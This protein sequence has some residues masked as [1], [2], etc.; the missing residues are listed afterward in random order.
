MLQLE[1][2]ILELVLRAALL[3]ALFMVLLRIVPRRSVGELA[4][5]DLVFLL[6]ITNAASNSLGEFSS[7]TD[8][9]VQI[10]TFFGLNYL[11]NQ[12]SYRFPAIERLLEHS[13]LPVVQNGRMLRRN[14]RKEALTEEELMASLRKEGIGDLVQVRKAVV[15]SDGRL[16]FIREDG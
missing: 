6:L 5:M 13:P 14:M 8:G 12:L 3:F 16:G 15:E 7:L 11:T 4:S 1:T 2:P 10:L 9:T